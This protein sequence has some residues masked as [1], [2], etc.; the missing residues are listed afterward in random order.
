MRLGQSSKARRRASFVLGCALFAIAPACGRGMLGSFGAGDYDGSLG[1]FDAVRPLADTG[2]DRD[3]GPFVRPD[4]GPLECTIARD[5]YMNGQPPCGPRGGLWQCER[6][7]CIP[8]CTPGPDAGPFDAGRRDAE[9]RDTGLRDFGIFDTGL[10]DFGLRD[11]GVPD[12]GLRD[13]GAPDTGVRA[14]NTDCDCSFREACDNHRCVPSMR[15]S[16]CANPMCPIGRAC[17]H[18][19]GTM[20]TCGPQVPVGQMCRPMTP[21]CGPTGFCIPEV[22]GFPGGYCSASCGGFGG[23]CPMGSACRGPG[24]AA[25][26]CLKTCN[27]ANECRMGYGCLRLGIDPQRVCWPIPPRS[28]NPMGSPVGSSCR[29]TDQCGAGLQCLNS[30]MGSWTGGYCTI[31]YCDPATL[32]CP[33]ASSCY[34][35]PGLFSLCLANCP[36][37]GSQSTCRPGYYCL[38]PTGQP[39]VCITN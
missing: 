18:P 33:G 9:P 30:F 16:C 38:G 32:P 31:E 17:V 28:M 22:G 29:Q 3:S 39:G 5:C 24:G 8:I 12:T 23:P 2:I 34:A 21:E 27:G 13:T 26:I 37:G 14:C 20:S 11:T 36:S 4:I 10:R 6:S 7:R 15:N 35:F 25:R 1:P 19:D